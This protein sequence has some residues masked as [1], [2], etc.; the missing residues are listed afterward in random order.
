MKKLLPI[1]FILMIFIFASC[2]PE[3][4]ELSPEELAKEKEAVINVNEAYN[5]AS[6]NEDFS[7]MVKTLAD[8]VFFFGTDSS[9]VIKTFSEFKKAI[10]RQWEVYDKMDYGEMH[11]ISIQMDNHASFASIIFG[12][13]CELSQKGKTERLYLRIARTL[14]KN[15]KAK[16]VIVS[17]IVGIARSQKPGFEMEPQP[18]QTQE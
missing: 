8:E 11:D 18:E 12:V 16:W 3:P 6:E 4:E 7:A 14:K 1:I 9:E 13:P 10:L 17:G 15:D 2:C 5:I